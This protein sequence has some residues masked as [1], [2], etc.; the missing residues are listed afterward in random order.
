M[1]IYTQY[2]RYI[3]AKLFK[4]ALEEAGDTYMAL[5][6]GNPRWD[7][8]SQEMPMAS[9]DDNSTRVIN[10]TDNPFEDTL[11][12]I[13][14]LHKDNMS[15]LNSP[16]G[17]NSVYFPFN[18]NE[19]SLKTLVPKMPCI[20]HSEDDYD[21]EFPDA[22]I[23]QNEYENYYVT[24]E[25]SISKLH[26]WNISNSQ[27]E[28]YT[29][30]KP[31]DTAELEYYA[32]LYLRGKAIEKG[33]I[34][35]CNL[36][37]MVKCDVS[38]V[39]DIGSNEDAYTGDSNQFWYGDRFWEV[40]NPDES[41]VLNT[42]SKD[43]NQILPHHLLVSATVNPTWLNQHDLALDRILSPRQIAIYT[44]CKVSGITNKAFYRVD[45]NIFNFGQYSDADL[46]NNVSSLFPGAINP[47]SP[48]NHVL[49]MLPPFV[50]NNNSYGVS[51]TYKNKFSFVLHDYVKG[52][53]KTDLHAVDRIGYVIG[54]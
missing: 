50:Y 19:V 43:A 3:K 31:T 11:S 23:K 27:W 21:I 29:I 6:F 5:G 17:I 30:S 40:V 53:I 13:K 49:Q 16:D 48:A 22:I 12:T 51:D 37:G 34:H 24:E 4:E 33:F 18:T 10:N 38:F 45:E 20:W 2:G 54:F 47:D 52:S 44:K 41:N 46:D 8:G 7:T 32:E 25:N 26:K 1:A 35:P 15:I 39:K 14:F 36:L 28:D 9:Y 42:T